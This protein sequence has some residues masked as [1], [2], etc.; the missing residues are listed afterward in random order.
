MKPIFEEVALD[1]GK[2]ILAFQY[3]KKDFE[4]SWHFHPQY[5]LTFIEESVGTKFIGDYIGP[6]EPGELVLLKSNLPHCWKNNIDESTSSIS[7]V[8]QWEKNIYSNVPELESVFEMF[9]AASRG[10]IFDEVGIQSLIPD[11]KNLINLGKAQL[12]SSLLNILVKLTQIK[13]NTL[14][15]SGLFEDLSYEYNSRIQRVHEFVE[16]EYHRK[17]YLK[18]L[19]EKVNM[20]EQSFSRFF[21]KTMGRSFFSFLNDYRINIANRLLVDTEKPIAQIS[22][23]CGY[24]SPSFFFRQF[25]KRNN[26]TPLKYRMS[27]RKIL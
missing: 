24:E 27:Y 12:Y 21:T 10:L 14:S 15:K 20:S 4:I 1:A 5:E 11:I 3:H 16:N 13:S 22:Y 9:R 2:T 23:A 6:Y 25:Q 18:E 8:I 7:T 26:C 19:A 17:I